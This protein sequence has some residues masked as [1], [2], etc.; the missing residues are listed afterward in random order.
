MQDYNEQNL[1]GTR[2]DE[3][4]FKNPA[5]KLLKLERTA[6]FSL[7]SG[8]SKVDNDRSISV[9]SKFSMFSEMQSSRANIDPQDLIYSEE[10]NELSYS[11]DQ[12][13]YFAVGSYK[14]SKNSKIGSLIV[15]K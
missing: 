15:K 7:Q 11:F 2:Y 8:T 3:N 1:I 10:L 6:V 5:I 4:L 14:T 13:A 9:F 12:D